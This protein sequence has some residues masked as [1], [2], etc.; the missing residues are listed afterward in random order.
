MAE[1]SLDKI[2]IFTDGA[3]SGNPGKG[4]AAY[5]IIKNGVVI[6]EHAVAYRLTTNNRMEMLAI[7]LALRNIEQNNYQNVKI[8]SDSN[9]V[10]S[11]FNSRWIDNWKRNNWVKSD[12]KPV[13]NKDIWQEIYP[14]N[15]KQKPTYIWVKGHSGVFYNERCDVL[16]NEAIDYANFS[17][18]FHID[19][20]YEKNT[21]TTNSINIFDDVQLISESSKSE[22]PKNYSKSIVEEVNIEQNLLEINKITSKNEFNYSLNF[23]KKFFTKNE[24]KEIVNIINLEITKD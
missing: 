20:N 7:L 13:L 15:Q 12:K 14:L 10:V 6:Y 17:N 21:Q 2:E 18:G 19:T 5:V 8:H 16:A 4:A 24:L 11:S 22:I 1:N 3:C 9:L 23:Q